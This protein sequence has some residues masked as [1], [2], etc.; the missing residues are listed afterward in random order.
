MVNESVALI[1]CGVGDE[2]SVTLT[3]TLATPAAA[4]VP[5]ITPVVAFML[6][7]LGKDVALQV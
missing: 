2:L 7:P 1:C 6:K 4:G 3:V 5:L